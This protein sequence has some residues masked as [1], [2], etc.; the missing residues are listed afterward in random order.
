MAARSARD[1][2]RAVSEAAWRT[3]DGYLRSQRVQSGV[4]NYGEVVNLLAGTR[5]KAGWEPVLRLPR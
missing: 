2:V 1:Q 3:Y 5:F 4:R